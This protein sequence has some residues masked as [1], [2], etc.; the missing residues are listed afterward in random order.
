MY[1]G[2][3]ASAIETN[4]LDFLWEGRRNFPSPSELQVLNFLRNYTVNHFI[5]P[6]IYNIA[7]WPNEYQLKLGLIGKFD[8]FLGLPI[9]KMLQSPLVL[10]ASELESFYNLLAK[11][12]TRFIVVP[13]PAIIDKGGI[14][15]AAE[16]RTRTNY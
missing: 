9:P 5:S 1:V 4:N 15:R 13:T 7:T 10:N 6:E 14:S 2:F 3:Q 11:S 8:G 16:D 12:D